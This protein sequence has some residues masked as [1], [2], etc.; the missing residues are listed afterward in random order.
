MD[1]LK[2]LD[3][4]KRSIYN[5]EDLLFEKSRGLDLGG[6]IHGRDL[7][8]EGSDSQS[9][10]TAYQ[11]VW[12]RNIRELLAEAKKTGHSFENFIDIGSGKG[13]A[14]FFA[15]SR[16]SFRNVIGVEFSEKL[17][18]VANNNKNKIR[19][20]NIYFFKADASEFILPDSK[21]LIFMFNPFSGVILE[22][23]ISNNIDNFKNSNS[24]I[25]YAN[26]IHRMSL[27]KFGFETIFR[28]QTR[29]ISLYEIP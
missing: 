13:K 21:N 14:C 23:F 3:S 12:C 4:I 24:I 25:A 8:A 26:D 1:R 10:A 6:V 19:A 7:I 17:V 18:D 11:A 15:Q 9:D 20:S 27:S 29:K 28:N 22:R 5:L 16:S 2:L